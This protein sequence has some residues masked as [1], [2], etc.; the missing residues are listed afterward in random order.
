SNIIDERHKLKLD[1]NK[2][3]FEGYV[4]VE[5]PDITKI[6]KSE[7]SDNLEQSKGKVLLP[8][9][10]HMTKGIE[11]F[12]NSNPEDINFNNVLKR[13]NNKFKTRLTTNRISR[14]MTHWMVNQNIDSANIGLI[15]GKSGDF[16]VSLYYYRVKVSK[17]LI[18]YES[19]LNHLYNESKFRFSKKSEFY[20]GSHLVPTNT[21]IQNLFTSIKNTHNGACNQNDKHNAFVIYTIMLLFMATGHRPVTDPF[22]FLKCFCLLTGRVYLN[23]KNIDKHHEHRIIP[24]CNTAQ[25]QLQNYIKY[26]EESKMKFMLLS[27]ELNHYFNGIQDSSMPLFFL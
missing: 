9:P 3:N 1:R 27:K 23:E 20:V 11:K 2:S 15:A 17:L 5:Y 24:L 25:K 19:F 13:I 8:L 10:K 22:G 14:Y 18:I 16:I 6:K 12:L 4:F 26:I 7:V 21:A